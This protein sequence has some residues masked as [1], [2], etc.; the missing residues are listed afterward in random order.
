[1]QIIIF[2]HNHLPSVK[3]SLL[4]YGSRAYNYT[5]PHSCGINP[6]K[7]IACILVLTWYAHTMPLGEIN[8]K[9]TVSNP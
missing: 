4:N 7:S 5:M 3:A 1:M 8:T 9:E 6:S 2:S